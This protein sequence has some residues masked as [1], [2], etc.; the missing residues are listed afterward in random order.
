MIRQWKDEVSEM[1]W[2][3]FSWDEVVPEQE[4]TSMKR[5]KVGLNKKN[6]AGIVQLVDTIVTG[7]T[8]KPELAT[9]PVTLVALT[10]HG[11]DLTDAMSEEAQAKAA[12]IEKRSARRDKSK[13]ARLDIRLFA[14]Y[15]H[16]QFKGDKTKLN[17]LG[18]DVVEFPGPLGVLPA[19]TNLRSPPGKMND[20][21]D[22]LWNAVRGRES[23]ELQKAESANGPWTEVYRGK[24]TGACCQDLEPG[25]QYFFRVRAYGMSGPGAWSDITSARAS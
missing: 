12:W 25:K 15:A 19:P 1:H 23:H 17:A 16:T 9:P 2:D 24:K 4:P 8:G 14:Q 18:L 6:D 10:A 22:L 20:C 5:L 21:I 3:A 7:A 13:A 11:E